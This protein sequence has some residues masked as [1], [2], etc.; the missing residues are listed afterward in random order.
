MTD[1]SGF[2][3]L[4]NVDNLGMECRL[5]ARDLDEV[6]RRLDPQERLVHE[7]DVAHASV[8]AAA[9]CGGVVADV[10]LHVALVD[11]IEEREA[12][13]V[14]VLG[15]DAAVEWT[16]ATDGSEVTLW[17][18]GFFDIFVTLSV[19]GEVVREHRPY[20]A[21][22]RTKFP[23]PYLVIARATCDDMG[24]DEALF[25]TT[26]VAEGLGHTKEE[27]VLRAVVCHTINGVM[28]KK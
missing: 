10:T 21:A 4:K 6:G 28:G 25:I 12:G 11:D 24:R 18:V 20:L 3:I 13:M 1:G 23:K 17:Q 5:A 9:G 16:P 19:V 26:E 8:V 2:E 22:V 27:L 14:L 15:A 7:L